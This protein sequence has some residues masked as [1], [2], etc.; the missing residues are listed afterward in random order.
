MTRAAAVGSSRWTTRVLAD[1]AAFVVAVYM[2]VAGSLFG[3]FGVGEVTVSATLGIIVLAILGPCAIAFSITARCNDFPEATD[4]ATPIK[5]SRTILN[6]SSDIV[7][8]LRSTLAG[9]RPP[10]PSATVVRYRCI[11]RSSTATS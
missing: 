8:P 9:V 11:G 2:G 3:V 7:M 5:E 10:S 6:D 4:M 1:G